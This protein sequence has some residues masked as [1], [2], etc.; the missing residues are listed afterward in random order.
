[1]RIDVLTLFPEMFPGVLNGSMLGKAQEKGAVSY[2][3]TNFRD[4]TTNK[5]NKV[6]DYPFGG[7]AGMVLMPQP[8]FD[9]VDAVRSADPAEPR[10]IL[11]SPQGKPFVQKDA[12]KLSKEQRLIFICGHYEGF[13]ERIP[14]RLATDEYSIGD[15]VMTGGELAAMAMID[16]IVRLLPGV[17]G[18]AVSAVTESFSEGLLEH[19]HYTRPADFRGMQVPEVL[20]SGNH[21]RIAEWR[22][23][24]SLK[25]TFLRR[26]DMLANRVYTDQERKWI[27]EFERARSRGK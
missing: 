6:D 23:K 18:N 8:L 22:H 16:S 21:E 5:H 27:S 7:G 14:R 2:H 24:E 10:V 19:P 12:E 17:L 15:F 1:M 4:F 26:P 3:I 11:T 13:D 9:A 25:R 20:L